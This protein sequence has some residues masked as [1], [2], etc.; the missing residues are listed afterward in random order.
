MS[1]SIQDLEAAVH[2][3][4]AAYD[5]GEA[6]H[7]PMERLRQAFLAKPEPEPE[8]DICAI[9]GQP[10]ADKI[11]H[12]EHWPGEFTPSS[13]DLVHAECESEECARAHREFMGRVGEKG[14]RDFL[15][16]VR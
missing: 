9:C 4:I 10:G 16:S 5:L 13:N 14:V 7:D 1:K 2:S 3:V 15:R 6:L 8:P 12:P 11:P